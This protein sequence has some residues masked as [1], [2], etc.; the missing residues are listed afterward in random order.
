MYFFPRK[1]SF[2]DRYIQENS[3]VL[4][5]RGFSLKRKGN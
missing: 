3:D 4:S 1:G 5:H 2:R